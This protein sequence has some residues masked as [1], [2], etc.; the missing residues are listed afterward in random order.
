MIYCLNIQYICCLLSGDHQL[1][2]NSLFFQ[3]QFKRSVVQILSFYKKH[4]LEQN[5]KKKTFPS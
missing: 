1:K 4:F 3:M 2:G 5:K